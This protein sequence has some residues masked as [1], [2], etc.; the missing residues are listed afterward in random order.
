MFQT[1]L[2]QLAASNI[3][4]FTYSAC[5]PFTKNKET[6]QKFTETR[7]SRYIIRMN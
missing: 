2:K 1:H 7:H 4:E 3:P 6:I 5:R